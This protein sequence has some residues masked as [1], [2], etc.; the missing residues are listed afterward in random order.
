METMR[1]TRFS[2]GFG[3]GID[4]AFVQINEMGGIDGQGGFTAQ[5]IEQE[6]PQLEIIEIDLV[7]D[8]PDIRIRKVRISVFPYLSTFGAFFKHLR[9]PWI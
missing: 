6:K 4:W 1:F 3:L 9:G 7:A 8:H 5:V 2:A